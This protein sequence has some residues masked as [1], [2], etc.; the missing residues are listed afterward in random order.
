MAGGDRSPVVEGCTKYCG[1]GP[2]D[3]PVLASVLA[4]HDH[5]HDLAALPCQP[6]QPQRKHARAYVRSLA[7]GVRAA[8]RNDP[9]ARREIA[10]VYVGFS[11]L[12]D[13]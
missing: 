11:E 4:R 12:R 3:S 13:G 8:G 6:N 1:P 10:Q 2:I 5:V 7:Q 9:S